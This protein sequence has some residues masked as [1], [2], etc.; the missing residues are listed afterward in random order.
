[1]LIVAFIVLVIVVGTVISACEDNQEPES[2]DERKQ[3]NCCF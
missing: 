3:S 1:M 2:E